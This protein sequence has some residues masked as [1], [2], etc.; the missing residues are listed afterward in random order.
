[1]G[2]PEHV[3]GVNRN[4]RA[5]TAFTMLGHATFHTYELA[6]P[7][8]VVVWLDEFS[9]S[10]AVL[11]VVVGLSYAAIGIGAL[12]TGVLADRV[13]ARRLVLASVLGMGVSM[14]IVA[15]SPMLWVLAVALVG[16]GVAASLYHPAALTLLSRATAARGRAFA[17]HGLAANVGVAAGPIVSAV[18]LGVLG[19]RIVALVLVLPVAIAALAAVGLE[20]DETAGARARGGEGA[21]DGGAIRSLHEFGSSTRRLFTGGFLLVFVLAVL[22]GTY[23]RGS[24]TF[25]PEILAGLPLFDPVPVADRTIEPSRYVY[26]G[27]LL[28]GGAGQ[29]AGGRLVEALRTESALIVGYVALVVIAVALLPLAAFGLVPLLAGAGALGFLVFMLPPINQEAISA[30]S[31]AN[32]RG[33]SFGFNYTALFGVGAVGAPL[34]GA[35]LTRWSPGALFFVLAGVALVATGLAVLLWWLDR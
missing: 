9:T 4:D 8:F 35:I 16:W 29:Y 31:A 5:V 22:Y 3:A 27:L 6:I 21:T 23:Y 25:L 26:A 20:F 32:V 15:L 28:L 10:P 33:L 2:R 7:L 18:L 17:L 30:Y 11:G 12:P 34:A 1:M 19:W 14:T 13:S 24:M